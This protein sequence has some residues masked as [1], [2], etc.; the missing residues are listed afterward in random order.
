MHWSECYILAGVSY[1][2]AIIAE[3]SDWYWMQICTYNIGGK[4][5]CST[6]D[7]CLLMFTAHIHLHD[8]LEAE[9][10]HSR[11]GRAL[12]LYRDGALSFKGEELW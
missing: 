6:S 12:T 10:S 11:G 9:L 1:E 8:A 7:K 3:C 5:T 2:N 4:E